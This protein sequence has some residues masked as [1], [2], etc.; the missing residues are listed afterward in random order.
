MAGKQS[1][2]LLLYRHAQG[3]CQVFLVHPGGPFWKAK[4]LGAWSIT[5]GE[6]ELGEDPLQ[7]QDD[8][9]YIA[10]T[11]GGRGAESGGPCRGGSSSGGSP[12]R[13]TSG[14]AAVRP[15][16]P[17]NTSPITPKTGTQT[18]TQSAI[19]NGPNGSHGIPQDS[20]DAK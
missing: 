1:A 10:L 7:A 4:D 11:Q 17:A 8:S 13:R 15:P 2:G 14:R 19:K 16:I 18:G 12:A 9:Q 5:K 20:R 3:V 6:F